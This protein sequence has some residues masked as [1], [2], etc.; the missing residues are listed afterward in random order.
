[1]YLYIKKLENEEETIKLLEKNM[2][3]QHSLHKDTVT[4]HKRQMEAKDLELEEFEKVLKMKKNKWEKKNLELKLQC[5]S[6]EEIIKLF[7]EEKDEQ[8]KLHIIVADQKRL[9]R[10]I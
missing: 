3:A 5:K 7:E 8:K 2:E 9:I 6:K 1:M 10:W 4:E